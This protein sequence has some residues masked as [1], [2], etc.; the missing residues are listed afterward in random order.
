MQVCLCLSADEG[1]NMEY[2]TDVSGSGL[3]AP[4]QKKVCIENILE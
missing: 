1:Q 4:L 2:V 3:S